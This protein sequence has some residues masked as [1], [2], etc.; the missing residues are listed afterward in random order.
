MF[1]MSLEKTLNVGVRDARILNKIEN[2]LKPI[3]Y[4]INKIAQEN[5]LAIY[6][7]RSKGD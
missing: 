6:S 7:K 2:I 3:G 5:Y 1:Y 4:K